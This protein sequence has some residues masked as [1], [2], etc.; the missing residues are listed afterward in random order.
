ME[1][2]MRVMVFNV[3]LRSE[4]SYRVYRVYSLSE[5]NNGYLRIKGKYYFFLIYKYYILNSY[6]VVGI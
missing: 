2:K 6:Y 1:Y 3:I 5:S 4:K